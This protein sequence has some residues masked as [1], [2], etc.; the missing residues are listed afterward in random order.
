[1]K[2]NNV[3]IKTC[4]TIKCNEYIWI[5]HKRIKIGEDAMT[6][7]MFKFVKSKFLHGT[8]EYKSFFKILILIFVFKHF[9]KFIL[10]ILAGK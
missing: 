2:S 10:S 6:S 4:T 5:V 1:M 9:V 3:S 8:E 7:I